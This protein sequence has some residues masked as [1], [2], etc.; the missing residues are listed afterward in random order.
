MPQYYSI[1]IY[2]HTIGRIGRDCQTINGSHGTFIAVNIAV[3][4]YAN[5]ENITTW[6]RVKSSRENHLRL[7][8]YLT[9]GRMI[10]VEGT[11]SSSIWTDKNGENHVQLSIAADSIDF[12]TSGKRNASDSMEEKANKAVKSKKHKG[13]TPA[14]VPSEEKEKLPF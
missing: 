8:Q 9:K 1:M 7:A 5:G 13:T 6:V 10:L 14:K 4:D 2:T 12:V 3:D 11:L